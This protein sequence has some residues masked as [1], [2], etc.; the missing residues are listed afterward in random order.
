[1]LLLFIFALLIGI[2]TGICLHKL[3]LN[4]WVAKRR[5]ETTMVSEQRLSAEYLE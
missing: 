2:A 5:I 3:H 1:M 4:G